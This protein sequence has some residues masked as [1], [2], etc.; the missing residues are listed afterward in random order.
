M[1]LTKIQLTNFTR[2]LFL[3]LLFL[4]VFWGYLLFDQR[5]ML[6]SLIGNVIIAAIWHRTYLRRT[7]TP[8][9][10]IVL[11]CCGALMLMLPFAIYKSVF[12]IYHAVVGVASVLSAYVISRNVCDVAAALRNALICTQI[13][14]LIFVNTTSETLRPLEYIIEG[15]SSNIV[16]GFLLILQSTYLVVRF[17]AGGTLPIMTAAITLYICVI[18]YG[19]ASIIAAGAILAISIF[20]FVLVERIALKKVLLSFSLML[21]LFF[22]IVVYWG[23]ATNYLLLYT[24]LGHGLMDENRSDIWELYVSRLDFFSLLLGAD[25]TN[26]VIDLYYNGNPHSSFIRMHHLFGFPYLVA[27]LISVGLAVLFSHPGRARVVNFLVL[28]ILLFRAGTDTLLFP[29]AMDLF[30]FLCI[31]CAVSA[32]KERLKNLPLSA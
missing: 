5:F 27:V 23:D 2:Q 9:R 30:F 29:T 20:F 14:I 7:L 8:H 25:F 13:I 10:L 6:L 19:R 28:A 26:T 31:F 12:S 18:A 17:R 11:L 1:R 22:L 21:A 16:T 4:T 15:A 3:T 24:K 32:K